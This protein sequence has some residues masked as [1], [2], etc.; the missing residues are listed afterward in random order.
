MAEVAWAAQSL[1]RWRAWVSVERHALALS[2]IA[3]RLLGNRNDGRGTRERGAP[4]VDGL[5][6]IKDHC[7]ASHPRSGIARHVHGNGNHPA[8]QNAR[9]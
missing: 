8:N 1:R 3:S 2:S 9:E 7:P 4:A 5:D 6:S